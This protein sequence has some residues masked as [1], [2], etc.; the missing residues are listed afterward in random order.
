MGVWGWRETYNRVREKEGILAPNCFEVPT[1]C[2]TSQSATHTV[3][4]HANTSIVQYCHFDILMRDNHIFEGQV[5]LSEF[6]NEGFE[7]VKTR[8]YGSV[9]Q[10]ME[11]FLHQSRILGLCVEGPRSGMSFVMWSGVTGSF[12][13]E[14]SDT[15]YRFPFSTTWSIIQGL[16]FYH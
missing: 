11:T 7:R 3:Q 5:A 15:H 14:K 12:H 16:I 2:Q 1:T 4:T 8:K 6:E 9:L 10:R 13:G